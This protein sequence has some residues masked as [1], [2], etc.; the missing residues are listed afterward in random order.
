MT[1][2]SSVFP[3]RIEQ[4][5]TQL[6]INTVIVEHHATAQGIGHRKAHGNAVVS[7]DILPRAT[8]REAGIARK[9]E[10]GRELDA[11]RSV[12]IESDPSEQVV[13]VK[14]RQPKSHAGNAVALPNKDDAFDAKIAAFCLESSAKTGSNWLINPLQDYLFLN[15]KYYKERQDDERINVPGSVNS[16]NWTYRIPV[17]VADLEKDAALIEGIKK[18]AA[19]HDKA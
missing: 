12:S 18:I 14:N 1:K 4:I 11:T 9:E 19:I 15:Q 2:V 7:H 10:L 17:S 13:G 8:G 5:V 3:S 16:F 6:V